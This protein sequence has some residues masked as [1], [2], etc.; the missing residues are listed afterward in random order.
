MFGVHSLK[1]SHKK[2]EV[3]RLW[4]AGNFKPEVS[5]MTPNEGETVRQRINES[6]SLVVDQ[7]ILKDSSQPVQMLDTSIS[8][9]NN[10][11]NNENGNDAA[12]KTEASNCTTV[13]ECSTGV[14]VLCNTQS[15][16]VDQCTGVLAEE[17][18]QGSISVPIDYNMPETDHLALVKSPMHRSHP[19]SS[20]PAFRASGSGREQHILKILEVYSLI[21]HTYIPVMTSCFNCLIF[22]T[23]MCEGGKVPIKT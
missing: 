18:L 1:E 11:G 20:S 23:F 17:P 12:R 21:C 4:T 7:Y 5:N 13:D 15:S 9:G 14:L 22:E 3:Y 6:K 2:G 10:S 16:E 19:R 8:V